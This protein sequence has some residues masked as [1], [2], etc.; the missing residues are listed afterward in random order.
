MSFI[1]ESLFVF[2]SHEIFIVVISDNLNKK[3]TALKI[4]F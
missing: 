1:N 3:K 4:K 2:S